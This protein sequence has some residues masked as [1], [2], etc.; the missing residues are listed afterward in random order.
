MDKPQKHQPEK[1]LTGI[2]S[3]TARGV[4]Y[5]IIPDRED[6]IEIDQTRLGTAL[7]GDTVQVALV[8]GAGKSWKGRPAR[9]Q[10][11]ILTVLERNKTR[12]IGTLKQ[13]GGRFILS[14]DSRRMHV[15]ILVEP[16]QGQT[17]TP[18][19]KAL[20]EMKPWTD[21]RKLPTG[22]VIEL[23]GPKGEN[24]TEMRSIA[25][26]H[27]FESGFLEK[28]EHE[29]EALARAGAAP[30]S[31]AARR[32]DFRNVT[33][34]TIDPEDA[35]DF[36][37]ALSVR[38]LP[39]GNIEVG[40]HI[41]DVTHFVRPG[42]A[43]DSEAQARGTSVYL[44]DRTIPMLP[45][46]L[47]NDIC[48]L[49]PNVDR[50]AF[51][52]VF[53]LTPKGAVQ[54]QWFGETIIHSDKRFTYE[55]AQGILTAGEGIFYKE[56]STLNSL[57]KNIRAERFETGAIDFDQEEIKF[58]LDA[59]GK[60]IA[61]VKKQRLD[62]NM[63]VEDFMLL[64]NREVATYVYDLG[65]KTPGVNNLFVYRIHDVPD[66]ER[67]EELGV[68]LR[69]IGYDLKTHKGVIS[70]KDINR[71]FK[72]IEGKPEEGLI[73]VA[74]IRS[75]AKAVYST[76]NIGHFG[77]SFRYYTHFT[78]PIRRYPDM[79]VHRILKSHLDKKPL[80]KN[81]LAR[82]EKLSIESSRRE[83]EAVEAERESIKY[84]QVEF[85]QDRVGE[86]FDAV[87]S[88]VADWGLYVEEKNTKAEG[89]VHVRAIGKDY[90]IVEKKQY[91]IVGEK[92]K[93]T[94]RLGDKVRVKLTGANL[95]A[96]TLDFAFI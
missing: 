58:K 41:A 13:E 12:F 5:V 7:D 23:L 8:A 31:E 90:Y 50:L 91:R 38:A 72:E 94:Y 56:L 14:P 86:E 66:S 21:S 89:L 47:S 18:Q 11:K 44:V 24:E 60:P 79:M 59:K 35:K 65:K 88:G 69:A 28:I 3:V 77:L 48:S 40:V 84:K 54:S 37:D 49:K 20:V 16:A 67:I 10:G 32:R 78:S 61:V 95:E 9:T 29:A 19:W 27:G 80:G 76:K 71:L 81:E 85:L 1:I 87:I 30:E 64:A 57:A 70:A 46:I 34:F 82:Y 6:D 45:E 51:A 93:K 53:T 68:F 96:K 75:M 52:A 43:I 39:D 17:L 4:G 62:T 55:E 42:Q 36:D 25:L 83:V 15:T 92:T 33:T 2:I 63:L 74:T 73:K 26:G 22:N